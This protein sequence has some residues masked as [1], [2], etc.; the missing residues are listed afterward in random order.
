[1]SDSPISR[2]Q[3]LQCL[4]GIA[5][6]V[7]GCLGEDAAPS[8]ASESTPSERRETPAEPTTEGVEPPGDDDER[9]EAGD[10]VT[11]NGVPAYAHEYDLVELPYER[12]PQFLEDRRGP[13]Y[14]VYPNA[15]AVSE[16]VPDLHYHEVTLMDVEDDYGH[17][18][19]R[20]SR[21]IMRLAHCYRASGGDERYLEKALS[22]SEAFLDISTEQ[23][24]ALYFPATFDWHSPD[25]QP[26]YSPRYSGMSQGTALTAYTHLYDITG[27]RRFR[28]VAD[29]VFR[30][31]TN[32]RRT[33]GDIW[34]TLITQTP[35]ELSDEDEEI[36]YFWIE[37]YPTEPPNHVLNGFVVG[38]FGLYDY[39]LEFR[40]EES[41]EVLRAALTTVQDHLE[42]YREP[43]EVSWYTL[44]RGYRGNEHYHSTHINQLRLLAAL[45]GEEYFRE[46]AET[47]EEDH[48]YKEYR[49]PR[50]FDDEETFGD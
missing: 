50:R 42:E 20:T 2:R 16:E 39:W 14:C 15:A 21:T 12:W 18:S 13:P 30:G 25:G 41:E 34:I 43:G 1:M 9:D 10:G 6:T 24:G 32:V 23:D 22:V 49:P 40:T 5:G 35:T 11:I 19:L 17:H 36:G 38:V 45:S 8:A 4:G 37:E 27:E 7:A 48:P 33:T 26:L 47:F 3:I 46:M 44:S 28:D 31:F 29:A